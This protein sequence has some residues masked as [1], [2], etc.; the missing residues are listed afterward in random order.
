MA[1]KK[2]LVIGAGRSGLAVAKLLI[3]RGREVVLTDTR[4]AEAV[5]GDFPPG[6][7][8]FIDEG[9]LETIFGSQV[10]S[11]IVAE[12]DFLVVSPGVPLT[13]PVVAA[14]EKAGVPVYSE[15]ELAYQLAQTPFIAITGTNGKTTTTVLTGE[16]FAAAGRKTYTVGNIGDPIA[17]HVE[18]AGPQDI[19]V[20]EVSSFQLET[21]ATFKPQ[22]AAILNISPDHLD[23]HGTLE[24]Y[25]AAKARIFAGQDAGDFLVLNADDEAVMAMGENAAARRILFSLSRPVTTGAYLKDGVIT[26]A[27]DGAEQPVCG[28]DEVFIKGDHNLANALAAVCLT[29]F[30][31]VEAGVI[32]QVLGSF[33]GVAHRQ[34]YVASVAGVDYINDSKGTNT[35]ATITALRAMTK[36]VILIAGGYDKQEDYTLMMEVAKPLVKQLILLGATAPDLARAAAQAGIENVVTVTDIQKA[37]QTAANHADEGDVVL[38]SPACASWGMF[39]NYEVRGQAFKDAVLALAPAP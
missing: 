32:A 33:K 26:I 15:V 13:I 2:I 10:D 28:V 17:A 23:R 20:A 30:A 19:F 14:A 1:H 3:N 9:K 18:E 21:T 31:G 7:Q 22:G 11:A 6:F 39:K 36:P 4:S 8:S 37:V 29:Y 25:I 34:E 35:N 16:I 12:L 38:L 27:E 5:A 24:N